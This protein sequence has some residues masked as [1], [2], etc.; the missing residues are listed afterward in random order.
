MPTAMTRCMKARKSSRVSCG[1][2][3]LRGELI[4]NRGDGWVCLDCAIATIKTTAADVAAAPP[5]TKEQA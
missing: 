3:V 2:Y 4:V 5:P 1:C